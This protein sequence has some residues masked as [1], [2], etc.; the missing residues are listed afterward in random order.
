[1]KKIFAV[2]LV[3]GTI[4]FFVSYR[5][6]PKHAITHLAGKTD[7]PDSALQYEIS[8]F[9]I[10]PVGL[11]R[12]DP[13]REEMLQGRKVYHLRATAKNLKWLSWLVTASSILDSYIDRKSFNPVVFRQKVSLQGK[14][15]A[16]KEILYD[17]ARGVMTMGGVKRQ[18]SS[19]TQDPLSLIFNLRHLDFNRIKDFEMIINTNQKNYILRG[20]SE[21][22]DMYAGKA[23]HKLA[24]L[25]AAISRKDK[26]PY[27][28]SSVSMVLLADKG[29]L[30]V[31]IKVFASGFL[32]N[33]KLIDIQ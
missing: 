24:Y 5:N 14:S 30:P 20:Q 33:A 23:L 22:H 7:K 12:I 31:L 28:K 8:V 16:D 17:Q 9:G 32:I 11:A 6:D 3:I 18:I 4:L 21:I 13:P 25:K 29:N 2:L 27:H 15:Y 26:N 1:M 19:G 10:L